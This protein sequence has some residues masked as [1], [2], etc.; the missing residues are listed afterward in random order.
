MEIHWKSI[1]IQLKINRNFNKIPMEIHWKSS[2]N[3]NE[4]PMWNANS[5]EIQLKFNGNTIQ[6]PMEIHQKSIEILT[7]HQ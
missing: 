6:I 4:I 1:G 7:K 2:E 5:Y 3:S